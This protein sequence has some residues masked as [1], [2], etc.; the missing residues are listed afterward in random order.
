MTP[1]SC[2]IYHVDLM[3]RFLRHSWFSSRGIYRGLYCSFF[4][5]LEFEIHRDVFGRKWDDESCVQLGNIFFTL[6][7]TGIN[8]ADLFWFF[9]LSFCDGTVKDSLNS[10]LLVLIILAVVRP[11]RNK[12]TT[13]FSLRPT[14]CHR[15]VDMFIVVFWGGISLLMYSFIL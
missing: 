12:K 14:T 8:C 4:C 5:F 9:S 15:F 3:F 13:V 2:L 11:F 6:T 1:Q 10:H 7:S